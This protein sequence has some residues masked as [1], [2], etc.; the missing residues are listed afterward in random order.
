[1]LTQMTVKAFKSLRYH[2]R[3]YRNFQGRPACF[4]L[5]QQ[6]KHTWAAQVVQEEFIKFFQKEHH[7][8]IPSSSVTPW[9]DPSLYFVN[10]GMNQFKPVLLGAKPPPCPRAVNSQK[11][12]R[13][14]GRHNDLLAVGTDSYHH[15]FFE[16]LGSWSF[17]DYFKE[18]ACKLAWQLLTEVYK[19]QPERLFVTY[20]GGDSSLGVPADQLTRDTWLSIG[21]PAERVLPFGVSDNFWEMGPVGPC[22][23]CSELHYYRGAECPQNVTHLVNSGHEDLIELWNVVFVQYERR[24]DGSLTPLARHHVDTGMGLE[25]LTATLNNVTSNYDTDLFLPLFDVIQ[26]VSGVERYSGSFSGPRYEQDTAY[27][28]VADHVRMAVVALADGSLP[29]SNA[30]LRRVLRRMFRA[31]EQ[32]LGLTHNRSSTASKHWLLPLCSAVVNTLRPRYPEL[33]Q[34]LPVVHSVMQ[35]EL[36]HYS[37]NAAKLRPAWAALVASEPRLA[38]LEESCSPGLLQGIALALP[39]LSAASDGRLSC[40]TALKLTQ[41]CGVPFE[42]VEEL[43]SL[44]N[45]RVCPQEYKE[46]L[47]RLKRHQKLRHAALERVDL[48]SIVSQL[49]QNGLL[50]TNTHPVYQ[51][52]L[53]P[54]S[55]Q[56]TT[57]DKRADKS[58][59]YKYETLETIIHAVIRDGKAMSFVDNLKPEENIGLVL[60]DTNFY[61]TAGG[62]VSDVGEIA[63]DNNNVF[64]VVKTEAVSDYVI[65]WGSFRAK[66]FSLKTGDTALCSIDG[67]HRQ[68]CSRHHTATHLLLAAIRQQTGSVTCQLSSLVTSEELKLEVGTYGHLDTNV[69]LDAE[70]AV[71][72]WMNVGGCVSRDEMPLTSALEDQQI[73]PLAGA[74][75]PDTVSVITARAADVVVSRELCCGTHVADVAHLQDFA[76]SNV[77]S[78]EGAGVRVL[79]GVC[80]DAATRLRARGQQVLSLLNERITRS[81]PATRADDVSW[82]KCALLEELPHSVRRQ[83][84]DF[85]KDSNEVKIIKSIDSDVEATK[86]MIDELTKLKESLPSGPVVHTISSSHGANKKVLKAAFSLFKGR[87]ALLILHIRDCVKARALICEATIAAGGSAQDWLQPLQSSFPQGSVIGGTNPRSLANFT[88]NKVTETDFACAKEKLLKVCKQYIVDLEMASELDTQSKT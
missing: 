75:Y 24:L 6:L 79:R 14:G 5:Q 60:R 88:A 1:M 57:V 54:N 53:S 36:Q 30:G 55:P 82:A 33:L 20:F 48:D 23:P 84:L 68:A 62:Q 85:C 70:R 59:V 58:L 22:G 25:R 39:E 34:R 43:A 16:M 80:G 51:Y 49:Q 76:V 15:T 63:L 9:N 38:A 21:V 44:Y 46:S 19:L 37:L 7:K 41:T 72:S 27:R 52:Y 28:L 81:S 29:N 47:D 11:C 74:I 86:M 69:I 31:A 78:S 35:F 45:C 65:H 18:E 67:H 13:V 56:H 17:G 8:F 12:I 73:T 4:V 40:D 61:A 87:N 71:Q 42:V 83:L 77:S 32:H 3:C 26:Q 2:G 10:A 50:P 64:E 66:L